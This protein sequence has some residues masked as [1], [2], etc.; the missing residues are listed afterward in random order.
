MP[1]Y[2]L[3]S[4]L[5][6]LLLLPVGRPGYAVPPA[7]PLDVFKPL[8]Y[9]ASPLGLMRAIR[10]NDVEGVAKL[11]EQGVEPD[12]YIRRYGTP[13]MW[14]VSNEQIPIIKLLLKGGADVTFRDQ[15]GETVLHQ[16]A[17]R[18]SVEVL[19]ALLEPNKPG[20][21]QA[22]DNDQRTP[23]HYAAK[24]SGTEKIR[25][26]L[27]H[28]ANPNAR[29]ALQQTPLMDAVRSGSVE[30]IRLLIERGADPRLQDMTGGTALM[31]VAEGAQVERRFPAA[32]QLANLTKLLL[33][34]VDVRDEQGKRALRLA[35][36]CDHQD[37]ADLLIAAGA[38]KEGIAEARFLAAVQSGELAPVEQL[39][40][41]GVGV[42][43]VS[44]HGD[45]ALMEAAEKGNLAL[46]NLLLA[47]GA[48][49][50]FRSRLGET[51][52]LCASRNQEILKALL[53]KGAKV[54][55]PGINGKTVLMYVADDLALVKLLLGAGAD[56]RAR[57]KDG[58]TA[59]H[60]IVI[61]KTYPQNVRPVLEALLAKGADLHARNNKGETP[62]A[63]AL[64]D[65]SRWN[66]AD[67]AYL[68][69]RG[70][71]SR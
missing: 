2:P 53:A 7:E 21:I 43:I 1:K 51:P 33:T 66:E 19:K 30:N 28:G 17:S 18:G 32:E 70:A 44:R 62:L 60:H 64:G 31:M 35:L 50:N 5:L 27:D 40:N 41:D 26:L 55:T 54:N 49:P 58:N 69:K 37:V 46:V 29:D 13:L 47:R 10:R 9:E 14:A 61:R 8:A 63:L 3:L 38:P 48:S 71:G 42:D 20:S 12:V 22:Q 39:L 34:K 65:T 24:D 6:A 25:L 68:R 11:L 45:T 67:L 23:L 16:A 4:M 56:V 36:E 57:D 59:L 15:S 52:L